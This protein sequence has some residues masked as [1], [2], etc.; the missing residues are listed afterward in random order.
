M[1]I[2]T[3]RVRPK[4]PFGR[5]RFSFPLRSCLKWHE[6]VCHI[7]LARRLALLLAMPMGIVGAIIAIAN[8]TES[9]DAAAP[10]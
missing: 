3:N 9:T 1:T 2:N 8:R 4:M 10:A 7:G 5:T 6:V